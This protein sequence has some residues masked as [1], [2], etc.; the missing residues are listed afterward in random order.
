MRL[1]DRSSIDFTVKGDPLGRNI[2]PLILL[3]FVENAFKYGISTREPSPI[4]IL[5]EIKKDSLYFSVHNHKHIN[6]SLKVSDNTGIGINNSRRRL[7]LLYD[8]QYGLKINDEAGEF[9]VQLNIQV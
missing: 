3:P 5:L 9:T 7:D 6:T 2:A 4:R 1:T 8:G